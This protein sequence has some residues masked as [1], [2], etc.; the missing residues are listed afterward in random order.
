[1]SPMTFAIGTTIADYQILSLL[2][3][4]GM[5]EVFKVRNMIT[6]RVEAMKILL[7]NAGATPEL[8]DRFVREIKVL[9]GLEHS[10]IASLRT[11]LRVENHLVMIM[12][13]VEGSSLD[14]KIRSGG[15]GV[16]RGVDYICQ[17]LDALSY[18]HQH[19]VIHR[20]IKPSNV[21]VTPEEKAKLTDFGIASKMGDPRLTATGSTVGSL[22]YMSP[23]QVRALALDA[24]SDI[25]SA[26]A[27]LYE[28]ITGRLPVQ[29]SNYYEIMK[30]HLEQS[31]PPPISLVPGIPAGLSRAIEKSLEKAP[32]AR[33]QTARE[34]R[35]ALAAAAAGA[36][37]TAGMRPEPGFAPAITPATGYPVGW[38][39]ALL[40]KVRKELAVYVGP[41][42]K[43]LVSREA[44]RA[45]SLADFYN[46]LAAEILSPA[47]RQK[48]MA[49]VPR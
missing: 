35:D 33:F 17:V 5:G 42:A 8:A 26:G 13:M 47:D 49:S 16:R 31:P 7:P 2:G 28:T 34:F 30:A 19:G 4:G 15:V 48:F 24:R 3:R 25:Y 38:D 43:L 46:A 41:M 18:A 37:A 29:G 11:A 9:A 36:A 12:E 21:L 6:D 10:N 23:E 22:Y 1:L 14:E 44:K 20:D 27:T 32:E 40:E 39:P 45:R